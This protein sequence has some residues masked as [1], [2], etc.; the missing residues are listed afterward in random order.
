LKL[1]PDVEKYRV[2]KGAWR[3]KAGDPFGMFYVPT[4]LNMRLTVIACD[5]KETG[6]DHVSVSL[7]KRCP[8]WPE[9][10]KVKNLFWAPEETVVQFHPAEQNYVNE[11]PYCLHLWRKVGGGNADLPPTILV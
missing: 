2:V 3:S 4:V 10:C 1:N 11:M 5:G 7:P 8:N 6:W 9:M